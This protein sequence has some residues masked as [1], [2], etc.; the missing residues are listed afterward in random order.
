MEAN[1]LVR[2]IKTDQVSLFFC[3]LTANIHLECFS[4]ASF[5]NVSDYS[6]QGGIIIFLADE[7]DK[8][9]PVMGKSRKIRRVVGSTLAA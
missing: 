7:N 9:C 3:V 2:R 6:S 5:A 4:G 1:K 8:R